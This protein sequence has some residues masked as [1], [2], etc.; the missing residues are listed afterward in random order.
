MS[1]LSENPGNII[2][3]STEAANMSY[4]MQWIWWW[5]WRNTAVDVFLLFPSF[6][7]FVV[8]SCRWNEQLNQTTSHQHFYSCLFKDWYSFSLRCWRW[9]CLKGN[10]QIRPLQ[11]LTRATFLCISLEGM[12][13]GT[14]LC[15]REDSAVSV[16]WKP[17]IREFNIWNKS[18]V[19]SRNER[20]VPMPLSDYVGFL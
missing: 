14:C 10:S 9:H 6:L 7:T 12:M 16:R 8:G 18:T 2:W 19:P 5:H 15:C 17:K 13:L 4:T 3:I 20:F 1:I 11:M